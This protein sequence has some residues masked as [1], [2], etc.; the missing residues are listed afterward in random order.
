MRRPAT[1]SLLAVFMLA[2]VTSPAS[3]SVEV[4]GPLTYGDSLLWD[5]LD[6]NNPTT[7]ACFNVTVL[8]VSNLSLEVPAFT[9]LTNGW[10]DLLIGGP[11]PAASQDAAAGPSVWQ[12][13]WTFNLTATPPL[14]SPLVELQYSAYQSNGTPVPGDFGFLGFG[15]AAPVG[16]SDVGEGWWWLPIT[17]GR[18]EPNDPAVPEPATLIVWSLLGGASWLGMRVVRQGRRVGRQA[19][20]DENRRAIHEIIDRGTHR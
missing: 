10:T 6:S 3:A 16:S 15:F 9:N 13:N 18:A 14:A 1:V 20:S 4:V 7:L 8:P 12:E 11:G 5:F 19:W 17:G 2:V